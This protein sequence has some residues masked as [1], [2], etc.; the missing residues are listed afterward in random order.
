MYLS[1][2]TMGR[3]NEYTGS[4]RDL[5]SAALQVCETIH[6]S[7]KYQRCAQELGRFGT[8]QVTMTWFLRGLKV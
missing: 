2:Y 3:V 4:M 7:G 8:D 5:L 6:V 1:T